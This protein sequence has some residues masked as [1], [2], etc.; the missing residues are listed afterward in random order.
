MEIAIPGKSVKLFS[1]MIKC[2][3]KLGE[4]L[5]L[6]AYTEKVHLKT[7]NANRSAFFNFLLVPAF[8]EGFH[9]AGTQF[10]CKVLLKPLQVAFKT[11]QNVE[12]CV[13]SV[14]EEEAKLVVTM[15]CRLGVKKTF[16]LNIEDSNPVTASYSKEES[17]H[18][19]IV[20][21]KLFEDCI[22]NFATSV[23][24]ISLKLSRTSVLMRSGEDGGEESVD[25]TK[26]TLLTEL[27]LDVKDFEKYELEPG[28]D[29]FDLVFSLRDVRPVLQFC[30]L[31]TVPI[32]MYMMGPGQPIVLSV[33]MYNL[34]EADFVLA[35]LQGASASH[36]TQSSQASTAGS[37]APRTHASQPH[38][39]AS[40][41]S[42]SSSMRQAT[43]PPYAFGAATATPLP[44]HPH[45]AHPIS[46]SQSST[47][48][49]SQH[50]FLPPDSPFHHA[51]R[52]P[53]T[54]STHPGPSYQQ[55]A[56]HMHIS[57]TSMEFEHSAPTQQRMDVDRPPLEPALWTEDLMKRSHHMDDS[58]MD[59]AVLS[60]ED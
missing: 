5:Y 20:R 13:L 51:P 43:S 39:H 32:Q 52:A 50:M 35:T 8:F 34:F 44:S 30:E 16:K 11:L 38:A 48:S 7:L 53:P 47:A 25:P 33:K 27:T 24:E 54:H 56:P 49:H 42:Q 21:P 57:Q 55:H 28:S 23:S 36:S 17:M 19:M 9:L 18:R 26:K 6:E 15:F 46:S 59:E 58:H 12:R 41:T 4:E 31:A 10:T 40:Q 22:A 37:H 3:G 45:L 2:L 1:H 60:D 29:A 14:I